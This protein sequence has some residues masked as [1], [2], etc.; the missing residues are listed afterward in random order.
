KNFQ[1][2]DVERLGT[3]VE[4]VVGAEGI[5][6]GDGHAAV[7]SWGTNPIITENPQME[8][9][10]GRIP[11]RVPWPCLML[12]G[13][14]ICRRSHFSDLAPDGLRFPARSLR[15]S[16][17]DCIREADAD[18]SHLAL[19]V[20]PPAFWHRVAGILASQARPPGVLLR[21]DPPISR[22]GCRS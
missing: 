21:S 9:A 8:S 15:R 3:Y 20:G 6:C 5:A 17:P 22:Y 7:L 19:R 16:V 10:A 12:I 14:S 11:S 2:M 4:L 1:A 13:W 18:C